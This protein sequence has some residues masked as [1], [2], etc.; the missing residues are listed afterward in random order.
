MSKTLTFEII[1][2]I[3]AELE[4]RAEREGRPVETVALEWLAGIRRCVARN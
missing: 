4:K 2:E 1:D 3:Y